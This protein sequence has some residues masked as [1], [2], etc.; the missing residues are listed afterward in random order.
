METNMF[1]LLI[2]AILCIVLAYCLGFCNGYKICD[3]ETEEWLQRMDEEHKREQEK[4]I[5]DMYEELLSRKGSNDED[6]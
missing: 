3:E 1:I 2:V 6:I 5:D 4:L